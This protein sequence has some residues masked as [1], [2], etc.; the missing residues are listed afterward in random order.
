MSFALLALICAVAILGPL[1]SLNRMVHVPVVIGELG[2]GILLG[3]T[4]LR[5]INADD[6][7]L[8]FMAQVGFALV[9]FGRAPTSP[10]APG[11]GDGPAQRIPPG[12]RGGSVALPLGFD[13]RGFSGSAT[14]PCTSC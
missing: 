12:A 10:P 2:V 6:P 4:G 5:V 9:M 3:Q 8:A 14:A 1:V 11:D 7:I 13:S